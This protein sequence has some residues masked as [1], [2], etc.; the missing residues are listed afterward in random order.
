LECLEGGQ[1]ALS[2]DERRFGFC[3]DWLHQFE[4]TAG[5]VIRF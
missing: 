1:R 3:Q 2:D 5:V 4:L